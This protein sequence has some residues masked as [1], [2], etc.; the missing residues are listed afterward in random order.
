MGCEDALPFIDWIYVEASYVT[1]YSG[2]PLA[3]D[4]VRYLV[5]RGFAL[6]GIFNQTETNVY[7]ATQADFLFLQQGATE[8]RRRDNGPT[9]I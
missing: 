1:L 7:G 3:G 4:I 6:R 8:I 5:E 9:F 2:Q